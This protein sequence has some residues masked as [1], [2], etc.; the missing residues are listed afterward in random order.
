MDTIFGLPAHPL[1]VH[2]V[3]V[4]VPLTALGAIA[5]V[6]LPRVRAQI[7]WYVAA[8]AVLDV[9]LVPLVTGSGEALQG[10]VDATAELEKHTD[11]AEGLLPFVV[12]LAVGVVALMVLAR[13][14]ARRESS[15]AVVE[16]PSRSVLAAPWVAA[17]VVAVTVLG[18]VGALVQTMRIGHSGATATWDEGSGSDTG[19]GTSGTSDDSGGDDSGGQPSTGDDSGGLQSGGGGGSGGHSN[20]GEDGGGG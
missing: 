17:M 6:L 12:A 5:C 1:L 16:A 8:G 20:G 13:L 10:K 15:G 7:G 2:A 9:L 18:G 11:M 19:G 3:V 14:R 4:L